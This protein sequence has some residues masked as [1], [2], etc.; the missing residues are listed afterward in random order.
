MVFPMTM[1]DLSNEL[2]IGL[3]NHVAFRSHG[4]VFGA[5]LYF[6]V[7]SRSWCN[8]NLTIILITLDDM[9]CHGLGA[10]DVAHPH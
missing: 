8:R 3:F 10:P 9:F 6:T 5:F 1:M 2:D 4:H 7:G